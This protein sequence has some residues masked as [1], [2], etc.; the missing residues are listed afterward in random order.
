MSSV[1]LEELTLANSDA[2]KKKKKMFVAKYIF[3]HISQVCFH[4]KIA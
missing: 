3:T 4:H 1:E 2:K